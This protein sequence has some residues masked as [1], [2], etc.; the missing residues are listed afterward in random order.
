MTGWAMWQLLLRM[1]KKVNMKAI[2]SLM[3]VTILCEE[4]A[5]IAELH[6]WLLFS[7]LWTGYKVFHTV[8]NELELKNA[9]ETSLE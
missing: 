2:S 7:S 1:S 3:F 9:G 6:W 8:E 5:E 4:T